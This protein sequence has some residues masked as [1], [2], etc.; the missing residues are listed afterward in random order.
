MVNVTRCRIYYLS[1]IFYDRRE[2]VPRLFPNETDKEKQVSLFTQALKRDNLE[3]EWKWQRGSIDR[4]VLADNMGTG[5]RSSIIGE[6]YHDDFPDEFDKQQ[7]E[8]PTQLATRAIADIGE[9]MK[10]NRP[11][12]EET[13]RSI[14]AKFNFNI[15]KYGL[16]TWQICS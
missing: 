5:R 10:T 6:N 16:Y 4:E 14:C 12:K 15:S 7:Q 13:K 3:A 11:R 1:A 2:P 9:G 8:D